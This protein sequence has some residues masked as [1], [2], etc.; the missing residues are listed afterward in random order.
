MK[1]IKTDINNLFFYLFGMIF[2]EKVEWRF[3]YIN[4]LYGDS[5][6]FVREIQV[7]KVLRN[8][9]PA[10]TFL[11]YGGFQQRTRA[12]RALRPFARRIRRDGA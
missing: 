5:A 3:M 1:K 12:V 2:I 9:V 4:L 10:Q 6:Y 7:V 8:A 11:S